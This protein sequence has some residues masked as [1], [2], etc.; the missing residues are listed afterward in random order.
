M[1]CFSSKYSSKYSDLA[2]GEELPTLVA[3]LN[4]VRDTLLRTIPTR[5]FQSVHLI[6]FM[7]Y[8]EST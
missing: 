1:F 2:D 4:R 6:N 8:S 7:K 5:K 3:Q